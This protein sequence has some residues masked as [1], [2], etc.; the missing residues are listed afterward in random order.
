G[1]EDRGRGRVA[2]SAW[3]T[4][5]VGRGTALAQPVPLKETNVDMVLLAPP[6]ADSD[7]DGVPDSIDN[8]PTTANP[9]QS[10]RDGNGV[11]DACQ[12]APP[13]GGAPTCGDGRVDPGEDCDD[14][15]NGNSDAPASNATCTTHC[16]RRA[17]CGDLTAASAAGID[18]DTGHCYV[19]WDIVKPWQ[20]A[21]SDCQSRGGMLPVITSAGEEMLFE[22]FAGGV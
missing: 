11:G 12:M 19:A 22:R 10:D 20:A 21:G 18:P 8:C 6:G 5:L 9:D 17:P 2:V 7:G 3:T 14:G 4:W 13:D 1:G 16:K 15:V